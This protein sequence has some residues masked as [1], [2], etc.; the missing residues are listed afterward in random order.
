METISGAER[1]GIPV[2]TRGRYGGP[3]ATGRVGGVFLVGSSDHRR[4]EDKVR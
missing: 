2:C 1:S 3:V 4:R